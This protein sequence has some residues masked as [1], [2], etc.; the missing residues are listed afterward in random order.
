[1]GSPQLSARRTTWTFLRALLWKNWI[2]KSR[3]PIATACEILVPVVFI[4]LLGLLKSTTN[5]IAVPTG[6]SD[7]DTTSDAT[8]GTSYNLFQP[9]GQTMEWV[10]A[11]LPK[12]AL[13]E[14]SMVGLILSLGLQSIADG[15]RMQELSA[16]DLATC[17]TGV[18][19]EGLVDTNTSSAYRVPT[20]CAE[21]VAPYKIGIAPDNA[22]TRNYF[23]E[24]MDL[25]YPRMDLLNSSSSSLVVPSFKE[26]VQFFDS[27]DALTEYVKSDDYGKGL[28]NPHIYAA[29][30]F[31]SAPEGDAIGSFASIEY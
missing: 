23:A 31:D 9:T 25:W 18:T 21:K 28:D 24:T 14:T 13:H 22:F 30:V 27:N 29:I 11:E 17:T 19:A 20:E 4:L 16:T 2:I 6:W 15:L 26:S 12:F 1:M 3:H 7:T 5:T 10:D 8:I